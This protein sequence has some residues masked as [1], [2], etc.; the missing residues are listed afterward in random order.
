M[1]AQGIA[2]GPFAH[3]RSSVDRIMLHVCLALLPTTAWGLYLFGWPAIY[4]WLLT[5]ASAVACEAACLYL[6]GRPLRRLLDGSA[7]LSG[8]LL[9]L[10]LP[11]WAPWWIAVGGSMF[12]IGIG[13]QLYGGVGQ[14]VFNPAML[15]RV[16][17]LIAFPLQMTTWALPLPLGTEGAPGWLEGLRI[18]FA[19]GALADGLSGATAL[20]HLQTELTLGHSAAQILDGYF[21]LLPAF[22]GYSGGSLG[23]TSE[24]LI[25]LGGLWLLALRIIHWEIPLGMLLTVGALAALAN[26]I[27]P[28][29]HGGGLF[30]LT[31]GG[32]LLGA[33]FIATDPVT[34]PISRSGRLIF[35]I[36]CGALVFVIRSW[37]N[38]PEAVAFAV[39]LMNALVPLIDRVCR[40]RAYGRNARGKPLVAAKWTRQVK[41][42]DKV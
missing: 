22:L 11:P 14:N 42:V 39:L 27:D 17:L 4:L 6:L 41:E 29:V 12:A 18:T 15:A 21:A 7:L 23:E 10:T 25:L 40:P 8:W 36:G 28:Q 19:G 16:A 37:G 30:H 24:L 35:A 3:D 1:S 33:L 5:C 26:Q 13:K 9:A 31:S 38:F 32:L 34:S 20:G 2:A